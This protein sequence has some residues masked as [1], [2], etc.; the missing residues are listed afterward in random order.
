M[1]ERGGE[2]QGEGG[3]R[4]TVYVAVGKSEVKTV[5]LLQWTLRSFRKSQV[6]LVHVHQPSPFIPT[7]CN[8]LSLSLSALE[9]VVVSNEGAAYSFVYAG[10]ESLNPQHLEMKVREILV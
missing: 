4:G 10:V 3:R 6:C 5:A 9:F 2:G 8:T 7:L 1:A